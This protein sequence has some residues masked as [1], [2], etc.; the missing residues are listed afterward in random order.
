MSPTGTPRV[1]A[2]V[3]ALTVVIAGCAGDAT[4]S[5]D[6][7]GT[8]LGTAR[9]PAG[10]RRADDHRLRPTT[11]APPADLR[12]P[13]A[14]AC[15]GSV[16]DATFPLADV[17]RPRRR[18]SP[19]LRP[20]RPPSPAPPEGVREHPRRQPRRPWRGAVDALR[21]DPRLAGTT[22]SAS[23][24]IEG[25]GARCVGGTPTRLLIPASNEKLITAIGA[26]N[27]L[28][29]DEH[30]HTDLVATGPI[31]DGVLHGDLVLIGGGDP[32]LT[33]TGPRLA[34]RAGQRRPAR[35][36]I[37]QVDG[38]LLVDESRYDTVRVGQNW[39]TDWLYSIGPMSALG[40][41][42]NMITKDRTYVADPAVGNG[43]VMKFALAAHGVAVDGGV[44]HGHADRV[45]RVAGVDSPPIRE[46]LATMLMYSDNFI[47]ELLIKEIGHRQTH[48]PGSTAAGLAAIQQVDHQP[49]RADHRASP[50]TARGSA[51]TTG[52]RPASSAG[53]S[54]IADG[55]AVGWR[56]RVV[57]VDRRRGQA[58][59]PGGWPGRRRPG[60]C[61][62]R[63]GSCS[64]R[65]AC[66]ATSRRP[67][68]ATSCSR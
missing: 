11:T 63:A 46:L 5:G 1:F 64:R 56:L 62:P 55:P 60:G 26:F 23:V 53:C 12:A 58:R 13:A 47:A 59:S 24:W 67:T 36:A 3:A 50:S 6:P 40:V 15:P 32:V 30:L 4:A 10:D 33:R 57:V 43:A 45:V 61:G 28:D 48:Q 25:P 51:A 65:R 18:P 19:R 29:L 52:A 44:E 35:P 66:R 2:L 37:T 22:V 7:P 9:P 16:D 49:V 38:R 42:H 41:D 34:R 8:M 27:L 54:Q 68:A 20:R 39:P 17:G 31:D 14:P 21:H